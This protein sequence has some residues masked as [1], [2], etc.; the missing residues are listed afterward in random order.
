MGRNRVWADGTPGL[1]GW[2]HCTHMPPNHARRPPPAEQNPCVWGQG[3][4]GSSMGTQRPRSGGAAALSLLREQREWPVH[5]PRASQGHGRLRPR[6]P[7]SP[8]SPSPRRGALNSPQ[9]PAGLGT[10]TPHWAGQALASCSSRGGCVPSSLGPSRVR[11]SSPPLPEN[12][13][14]WPGAGAA[15]RADDGTRTSGHTGTRAWG[16]HDRVHSGLVAAP[17]QRGMW[18]VLCDKQA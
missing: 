2:K 16:T 4:E 7:A 17:G 14:G 11:D 15:E 3:S 1:T 12:S 6:Y 8:S 13:E 9:P 5:T 10:G 18:T